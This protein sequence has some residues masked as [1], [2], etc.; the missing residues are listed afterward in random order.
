VATGRGEALE[1]GP[2]AHPELFWALRGGKYCGVVVT[3]ATVRLAEVPSLYAGSLFFD[4]PHL[5][6]A[7]RGWVEWT[8]KAHPRVTTSAAMARFP[9]HEAVPAPL[10]GRRL[11]S[12]RFAFPGAVEEGAALAEPLRKLAPVYID[13][14][15]PM[16][17][18]DVARIHNDPTQPVP[19]IV[20]GQMFTHADARLAHV[21]L[22][23]LAGDTPIAIAELRHLGEQTRRDVEG[24]S[25]VSGRS[26][27]F[28][29]GWLG[30]EP[31]RFETEFP[32]ASRR[33][34]EATAE[35]RSKETLINFLGKTESVEQ[36]AAAWPPE[37]F[38]RLKKVRETYDPEGVLHSPWSASPR[39]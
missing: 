34:R 31:R 4:T 10:R 27:A 2:G 37:T 21:L 35:W 20:G 12:V 9:P 39:S 25:A 15:G 26:A 28:A 24:G 18:A 13:Q 7:F 30:T 23:Q 22:A 5:D 36:V 32:A 19:A 14:L 3:R 38:A 8:A 16:P 29:M 1:V 33:L 11:L 6:A 17:I